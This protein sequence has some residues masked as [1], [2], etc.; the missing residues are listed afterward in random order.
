MKTV[1]ALLFNAIVG[2]VIAQMLGLPAMVGAFTL[3]LVAAMVGAMPKGALRAGVFTEIW[4][5]SW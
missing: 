5:A 4:T 3:N 1:L 2:A